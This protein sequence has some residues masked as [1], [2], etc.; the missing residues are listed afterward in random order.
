MTQ[1]FEMGQYNELTINDRNI[2]ILKLE[3]LISREKYTYKESLSVTRWS[4]SQPWYLPLQGENITSR[5]RVCIA[6]EQFLL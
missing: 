2:Y 4:Q 3:R 6:I 1:R 5:L